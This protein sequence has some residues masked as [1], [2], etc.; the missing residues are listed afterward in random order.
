MEELESRRRRA[1]ALLNQNYQPVEV[2]RMVDKGAKTAGFP[3][4]L[5]TCPPVAQLI[6]ALFGVLCH[7]D[8]IGRLLRSMGW[9]PQKP[10]RRAVEKMKQ[11]P[12]DGYGMSGLVFKKNRMPD[13]LSGFCG[14]KRIADGVPGSAQLGTAGPYPGALSAHAFS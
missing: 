12:S 13:G 10:Q 8:H 3:T 7:V 9:S 4:D 11:K 2:A 6:D 14:R 1:I 5:W